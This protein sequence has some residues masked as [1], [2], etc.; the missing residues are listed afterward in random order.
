MKKTTINRVNKQDI[1]SEKGEVIPIF[2]LGDT[3][4]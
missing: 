4:L 1:Q 2:Q 3:A